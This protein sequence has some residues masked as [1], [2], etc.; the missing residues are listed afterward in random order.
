MDKSVDNAPQVGYNE[1]NDDNVEI[2]KM[3]EQRPV[4]DTD[5]RHDNL[6]PDKNDTLGDAVYHGCGNHKCG[7]GFYILPTKNKNIT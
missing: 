6:V 2:V 1:V 5:C 7:V 4:N 3:D